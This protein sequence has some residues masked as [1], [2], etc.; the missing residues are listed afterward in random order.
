MRCINEFVQLVFIA[1]FAEE[2]A[3]VMLREEGGKC[4]VV[5]GGQEVGRNEVVICGSTERVPF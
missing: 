5:K 3:D 4:A 1:D 2:N